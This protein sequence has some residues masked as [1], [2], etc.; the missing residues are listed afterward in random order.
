MDYICEL[1]I[2]AGPFNFKL[3]VEKI[4]KIRR[5]CISWCAQ[6]LD[7]CPNTAL[8]ITKFSGNLLTEGFFHALAHVVATAWRV[9]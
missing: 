3:R 5:K 2:V 9:V 1:P 6:L 4:R 7:N 8:I